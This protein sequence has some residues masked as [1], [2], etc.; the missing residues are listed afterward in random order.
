VRGTRIEILPSCR[1]FAFVELGTIPLT[2]TA[3][4][5]SD[6]SSEAMRG[7]GWASPNQSLT[8]GRVF[9]PEDRGESADRAQVRLPA[10][11]P[12]AHPYPRGDQ[13]CQ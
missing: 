9:T 4:G 10:P 7:A 2:R 11:D 5:T 1:A 3:D 13:R 8:R 6:R 12:S